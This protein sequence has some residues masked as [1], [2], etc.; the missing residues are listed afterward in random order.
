ML[1]RSILQVLID[2]ASQFDVPEVDLAEGS[3]YGVQRT[4][5]Q[6]RMFPPLLTVRCGPS[7]PGNAYVSVHYRNHWFWVEDR[8]IQSKQMFNFTM[9]LFSLTETGAAQ[10][11]PI[12]TIPAR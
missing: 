12:V 3:V 4:P 5:Q 10:A 8:D 1:S 11:A 7:A 6:K 2:L 9:L